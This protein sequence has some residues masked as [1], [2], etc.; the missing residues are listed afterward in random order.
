MFTSRIMNNNYANKSRKFEKK[1][2]KQKLE[3]GQAKMILTHR[4]KSST[5]CNRKECPFDQLARPTHD[6]DLFSL[7]NDLLHKHAKTLGFT[8][9]ETKRLI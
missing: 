8:I 1:L 2:G 3:F 6:S 5:R 7:G 9:T 4:S